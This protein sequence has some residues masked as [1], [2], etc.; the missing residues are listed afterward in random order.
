MI[1]VTSNGGSTWT[2]E[3]VPSAITEGDLLSI[4]CVSVSTCEV[5]G[6][7]STN[8]EN[9]SGVILTTTNGGAGSAGWKL[10]TLPENTGPLESVSCKSV[11]DCVAVGQQTFQAGGEVF[12]TTDGGSSWNA[13]TLPTTTPTPI[14][15]LLGIACTSTA[16]CE[17]VG[18]IGA[19]AFEGTAVALRSSD[20]G[21]VWSKPQSV[22]SGITGLNAVSCPSSTVCDAVG[23][24]G[25]SGAAAIVT[26][27]SG[28]KWV[29]QNLPAQLNYLVAITCPLVNYCQA[30]GTSLAGGGVLATYV[31]PPLVLTTSKLPTA[32]IDKVFS[33]RLAAT[34][35]AGSYTWL[36]SAG[37]LPKG[38]VL[39]SAGVISGKP[40]KKGIGSFSV[41]VRDG[42]GHS[43]TKKFKLTVT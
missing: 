9:G 8:F 30:G 13:G 36:R 22:P 10:R 25:V 23:D 41:E 39:S 40:T 43:A 12:Y 17:A 2:S 33:A 29:K 5:V 24:I 4:S 14:G 26:T 35:G 21:K 31:P 18:Y 42:L 1:L 32:K 20:G 7:T 28:S 11:S 34:G 3:V 27:D 37:A 15:G 16:D 6:D 38:L 19:Q